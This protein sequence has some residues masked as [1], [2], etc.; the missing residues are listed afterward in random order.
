M[1]AKELE[2]E[3]RLKNER[4]Q[5]LNVEKK[6]VKKIEVESSTLKVERKKERTGAER[7]A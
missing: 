7:N 4:F 5:E 3:K 6:E 1:R 2:E